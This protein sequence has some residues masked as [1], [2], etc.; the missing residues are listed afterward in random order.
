MDQAM[1]PGAWLPDLESLIRLV[2]AAVLGLA[3]GLEREWRGKSAGLRT[4]AL[5]ALSGA[6]LTRSGLMLHAEIEAA[7]GSADPLRVV[8]G[9][10]QAL[11]FI[12]AGL[13]FVARRGGVK[14]LTTAASLWLSAGIGIVAG[15][16]QYG[17][18][19][20]TT[21]IGLLLLL[22]DREKKH[23]GDEHEEEPP[24]PGTPTGAQRS[25]RAG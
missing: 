15:A 2:L 4:H 21:V 5:I 19:I 10:A 8:Q 9:I 7:G 16:G 13:V 1:N 17:L 22:A 14:N 18:A 3:L 24:D 12:G 20:S 23:P 6:L 25:G 11:G